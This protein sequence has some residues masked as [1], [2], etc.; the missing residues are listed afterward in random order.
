MNG[1]S[2]FGFTIISATSLAILILKLMTHFGLF[3]NSAFYFDLEAVAVL[4]GIFIGFGVVIIVAPW[5]RSFTLV[6]IVFLIT[7]ISV[8]LLVAPTYVGTV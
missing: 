7:V 1:L 6:T 4:F 5:V 3:T 8:Y 2:K